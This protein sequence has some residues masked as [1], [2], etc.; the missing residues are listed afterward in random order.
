MTYYLFIKNV[1]DLES[2]FTK[3]RNL[4]QSIVKYR[5]I[6]IHS[7]LPS[8]IHIKSELLNDLGLNYE[9]QKHLQQIDYNDKYQIYK[10]LCKELTFF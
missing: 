8:C 4:N 10:C 2:V 7:F 5:E 3:L 1:N 9:I 6:K